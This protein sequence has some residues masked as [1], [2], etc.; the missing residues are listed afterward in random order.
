MMP[1]N[2]F[3]I[4]ACV[5]EFFFDTKMTTLVVDLYCVKDADSILEREEVLQ[6][7]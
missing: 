6:Y 7:G 2:S 4:P 5:R 3:L 1:L